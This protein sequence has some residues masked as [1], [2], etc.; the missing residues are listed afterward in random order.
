MSGILIR[1]P[2]CGKQSHAMPTFEEVVCVHCGKSFLL[3]RKMVMEAT[4]TTVEEYQKSEVNMKLEEGFSFLN[5]PLNE[6]GFNV[7]IKEAMGIFTQIVKD[8]NEISRAWFGLFSGLLSQ[9]RKT[10][11]EK[12]KIPGTEFWFVTPPPVERTF[13]VESYFYRATVTR[14]GNVHSILLD[15]TLQ[16]GRKAH[17]YLHNAIEKECDE[18]EKAMLTQ[19]MELHFSNAPQE[20]ARSAVAYLATLA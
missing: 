6:P 2:R 11:F 15:S 16:P 9:C 13:L 7:K 20:M 8:D 5:I 4:N 14:E 10:F 1:C 3:P 18:A 12:E 19:E 17:Y